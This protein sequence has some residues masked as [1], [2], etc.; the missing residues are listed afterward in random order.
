MS[1]EYQIGDILTRPK[2]PA[3]HYG[4]YV[5]ESSTT[6]LREGLTLFL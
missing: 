3:T 4:L 1:Y 6:P 2:G 5:A